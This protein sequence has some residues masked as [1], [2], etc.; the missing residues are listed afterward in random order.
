MSLVEKYVKEFV[1]LCPK[2]ERLRVLEAGGG[3]VS[4]FSLPDCAFVTTIDISPEQIERNDYAQ[5]RI[6]GDLERF[7]FK[8]R[9]F[10]L[11]IC[12]D[13]IEHL[14]DP[15]SA[16]D[17]I[18]SALSPRG[19]V[20]IGAP[21]VNSAKGL[22]TKFTPHVFHVFFYRFFLR[23][24]NAGKPGYPPFPTYLNLFISPESLKRYVED[25]S[26]EVASLQKLQSVHITQL[27]E[28]SKVLWLI[29]RFLSHGLY[30]ISA[31]YIHASDTDF[32]M[33]IKNRS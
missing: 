33:I 26:K 11:I 21:I 13:V 25:H 20:V 8:D 14:K 2:K 31:G 9:E 27:R 10:D 24:R 1:R 6:V 3:S 32:M 22:I 15:R 12:W 30:V 29:Y 16:L 4:H 18:L 5:E 19:I 7:D 17:N 28:Q 23:S